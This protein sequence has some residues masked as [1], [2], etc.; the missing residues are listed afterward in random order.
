MPPKKAP[1]SI[2]STLQKKMEVIRS[3]EDGQTRP[4]VCR[5]MNLPPLT[6]S[7][8]K[9]N[10]FEI[11][12]TVQHAGTVHA[13]QVSYSRSKLLQKVEKLLSYGWMI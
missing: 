5:S 1:I 13:T 8:I 7:T 2:T 4:D 6:V 10:V 12:Q 11:K 3:K 9:K